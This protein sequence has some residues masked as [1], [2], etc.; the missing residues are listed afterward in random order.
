MSNDK[1]T[2]LG[3]S[4][5]PVIDGNVDR[6]VKAILEKS[7]KS[8]EFF[9][10]SELSYGPCRACAHLCAGDNLC[11]LDDDLKH[12]YSKILSAEAIVLGTPTYFS[13]MNGFMA[14]FLERLWASAQ[15]HAFAPKVQRQVLQSQQPRRHDGLRRTFQARPLFQ[16]QK[17]LSS[18][19]NDRFTWRVQ[20]LC[21]GIFK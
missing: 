9:N 12:L 7:G 18:L 15:F 5:S 10:L 17:N 20:M 14:I 8:T 21:V 3:F 1:L 13:N 2:V 19:I 6:M 11:K 16:R 4:S